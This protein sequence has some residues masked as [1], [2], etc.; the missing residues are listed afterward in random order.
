MVY[1]FD[2]DGTLCE[3]DGDFECFITDEDWHE[4]YKYCTPM[5]DT[6][7][8]VRA[9]YSYGH[10]I[11]I[12]TSRRSQDFTVTKKWLEQHR[13]P[14]HE[15]ILDKPRADYY[16]DTNALRPEELL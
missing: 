12:H 4:Y 15:L 16:V 5:I 6:I 1:I 10:R 13:V 7:S 14:F 8:Q 3:E 11:I 9:M 2:L